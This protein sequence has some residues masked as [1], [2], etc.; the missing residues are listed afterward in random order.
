MTSYIRVSPN[1]VPLQGVPVIYVCPLARLI[2]TIDAVRPSHLVTILESCAAVGTP[3]SI[4]AANHLKIGCH[5]IIE[6]LE[7]C[8]LPTDEH[9]RQLIEF[10][11]SWPREQPIVIHCWA[12]I[13]R[14]TASAYVTACVHA[15]PGREWEIAQAM[16]RASPTATPN[17]RIVAIADRLLQRDGR[18]IRAIAHI[19][20]GRE[21]FSGEPFALTL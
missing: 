12:G 3:H 8:V 9:V 17:G 13:S 14:S 21:A 15:A 11:G 19:G 1:H 18:M 2:E 5:D 10:A 7:G 16:R 4:E 20:R 6:P